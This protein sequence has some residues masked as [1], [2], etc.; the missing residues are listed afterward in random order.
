MRVFSKND[1]I[2]SRPKIIAEI[3]KGAVFIY[4]TDTI[5]GIGCD[6][7]NDYSVNRIRE[8]KERDTK[9]FS[10]IAPSIDWIKENC[11]LNDMAKSWLLKLPGTYTLVLPLKNFNAVCAKANMGMKTVGVR[12]PSHWI[13][14]LI[15]DAGKPVITTSVNISGMPPASKLEELEKFIAD[16]IIFDG[17]KQGRPSTIVDTIAG[18]VIQR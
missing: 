18:K 5:Y 16:F 12:I 15:A 17:E 4:P 3:L 7:T 10:I 6:A 1:V 2:K 9:P 11:E 13:A 14:S 8:L